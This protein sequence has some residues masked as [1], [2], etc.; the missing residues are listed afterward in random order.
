MGTSSWKQKGGA[1]GCGTVQKVDQEGNKD[2]FVK[3]D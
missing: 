3:I 2:W 1:M